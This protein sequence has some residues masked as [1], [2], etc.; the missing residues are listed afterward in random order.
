MRTIRLTALVLSLTLAVGMLPSAWAAEDQTVTIA[1]QEET[2]A[3]TGSVQE[4][5]AALV[6]E[7]IAVAAQAVLNNRVSGFTRSYPYESNVYYNQLTKAQKKWY[8][9][10]LPKAQ[11]FQYVCYTVEKYGYSAMDNILAA[12]VA[13]WRDHPELEMYFNMAEVIQ[14]ERLI[15]LETQYYMPDDSDLIPLTEEEQFAELRHKLEVFDAVCEMVI[16]QMPSRLS[17]YDKYRYLAAFLSARAEYQFT[18]QPCTT[19]YGPIM[20]GEAICQGYSIAY[21][22]LC[23]KANLFCQLVGGAAGDEGHMW[24]LVQLSGGTYHVD[25]TWSD[26]GKNEPAVGDWHQYFMLTQDEIEVD[27]YIDD[28]TV[29]TGLRLPKPCVT[30]E[31]IAYGAVYLVGNLQYEVTKSSRKGKGTVTVCAPRKR[32]TC[33]YANIPDTI[34]I[35]G[36]S[37][38]VTVIDDKAFR[39]C[40]KLANVTV[41]GNVVEIGK[42]A[43]Y[44]DSKLSS[45]TISSRKLSIVGSSAISGIAKKAVIRIPVGCR[46]AYSALF[47]SK[48]GFR[49]TMKLTTA[50]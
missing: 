9:R 23:S 43:F 22:Y 50:A 17:T 25:V 4:E 27:H 40:P 41:G 11:N 49:S 47:N 1:V 14:D 34:Q 6:Q 29:A 2:V 39:N 8:D 46:K 18:G 31:P 13:L 36:I 28:G 30:S 48:A 26:S 21:R 7:D 42:Q 24:N 45:L 16:D 12:M 5:A 20:S 3:E 19:A 33:T 35:N 10:M 37:F 44:S 32:S 38:S 15:A